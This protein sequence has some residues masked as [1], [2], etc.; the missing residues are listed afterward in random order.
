[1]R[2]KK[3]NLKTSHCAL[4]G[5]ILNMCPA[6]GL[7]VYITLMKISREKHDELRALLEDTIEYFCDENMVS[8][9]VAWTITECLAIAKQAELDGALAA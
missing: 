1:M 3:K 5:A 4:A 8:G 7:D 9:Q 6:I 2:K